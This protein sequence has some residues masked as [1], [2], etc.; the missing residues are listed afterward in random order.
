MKEKENKVTRVYLKPETVIGEII[1]IKPIEKSKILLPGIKKD[2]RIYYDQHPIQMK[3][4][5]VSK[6]FLLQEA[7][8]SSDVIVRPGDILYL[9]RFPSER[10]M[11]LI[12]G[13]TLAIAL[14]GNVICC[15]PDDSVDK[16]YKSKTDK[17]IN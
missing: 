11:V 14:K 15:I 1:E 4:V 9:D 7:N 3:V 5:Y 16:Y 8:G 13:M 6:D 12:N 17:N 10:E 2:D